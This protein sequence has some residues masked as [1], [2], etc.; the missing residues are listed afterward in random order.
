MPIGQAGTVPCSQSSRL[1]LRWCHDSFALA[2]LA[3]VLTIVS[4]CILPVLPF[5][6]AR[7]DQGFRRSGLPLLVGMAVAFAAVASLAAFAGGWAV[8]L[9]RNVRLLAL[10]LIA[11]F[12]LALLFPPLSARLTAPFVSLGERLSRTAEE[13]AAIAGT[14][15]SPRRSS[16]LRQACSGRRARAWCW[17]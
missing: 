13:R 5:V 14:S 12:G 10:V 9:N 16:V 2:Y 6:F 15:S 1:Q 8:E 17:A 3:G 7:V 4:P 11:V